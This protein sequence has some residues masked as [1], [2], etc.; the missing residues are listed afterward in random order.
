VKI[1]G[2]NDEEKIETSTDQERESW[3]EIFTD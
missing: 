2:I 3:E 1:E